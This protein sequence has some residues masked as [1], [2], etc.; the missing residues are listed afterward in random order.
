MSGGTPYIGSKI[1]LISKAEIRYEGILY[2]IDTE[3][4][5][6]ALAKGTAGR[7]SGLGGAGEC[8][9]ALALFSLSG[10]GGAPAPGPRATRARLRPPRA[11]RASS[12]PRSSAPSIRGRS[13][14]RPGRGDPKVPGTSRRTHP[15]SCLPKTEIRSFRLLKRRTKP[16]E[17]KNLDAYL[18]LNRGC[19]NSPG[20]HFLGVLR[21]GWWRRF[22]SELLRSVLQTLGLRRRLGIV[23]G[24][25][26][27]S[28]EP[29][30]IPFVSSV[31]VTC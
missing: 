30:C 18:E 9:A 12:F 8:P 13:A 28:S 14:R 25:L 19:V 20:T 16:G 3:N 26:V 5:T 4:S 15:G 1:S 23:K 21:R 22:P 27:P 17:S 11:P 10:P 6:V 31:I 29:D 2:T 7:A 24:H